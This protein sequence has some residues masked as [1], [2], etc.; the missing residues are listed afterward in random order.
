MCG[1]IGYA[2]ER[3]A[4]PVLLAGL[5]RLEYRG[6][7][8]AGVALAEPD[9]LRSVRAVGQLAHLKPAVE[10]R[11]FPAARDRAHAL[12][13]ARPCHR[14]ERPPACRLRRGRA[15]A[16]AERDRRELPRRCARELQQAGHRFRVAR[17]TPRSSRTWSRR[18]TTATCSRPSRLR[19]AAA[20]GPLRIR[21]LPPRTS[22]GLLVATRRHCPLVVGPR[23]R[24]DVSVVGDRRVPA[25][26][27]G[28]SSC[29][30]TT[31]SSS[32]SAGDVRFYDARRRRARAA[33]DVRRLGGRRRRQ[34]RSRE[35]HARRRSGSS[36]APSRRRSRRP[37]A[38][39][40]E[41][42]VSATSELR[43]LKR[44]LVL[45]CG[46]AYHAGVVGRYLIEEWARRARRV[47]HRQ[48]VALP[49]PDRRPGDARA[50][51]SRS[52][53]RRRTRWRRCGWPAQHG[54]PD[55]RDHERPG[56]ADHAR[57]RPG[58]LHRAAGRRWASRRRRRSPRR[59]SLLALSRCGS[60]R[61][62]ARSRRRRRGRDRGAQRAARRSCASSSRATIRSRRSPR[63]TRD[64]AVL[65]LP[66]PPRRPARLPRGRA[67]AEGDRLR[68]DRGATP[69]AR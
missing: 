49:Q 31:S 41:L 59:S 8:S 43:G 30:K 52:R 13:D 56:L 14:G 34:G 65:P 12:G 69:P 5:G 20:R 23:R 48:R 28:A 11:S 6:Y 18:T 50:S 44:I 9:G 39:F 66:R 24:R 2:G 68:P 45:A 36:R 27:R 47:R 46:T 63:A 53:A 1:I 4:L 29:S 42:L 62:E 35:L 21:R 22:P 57:G 58:A 32:V 33:R 10:D 25:A 3:A 16:R 55:A 67:E 37:S 61:R 40:E 19:R 7:D 15:R 17:R 64:E 38:R 51:A 26:R 60:P 54:V